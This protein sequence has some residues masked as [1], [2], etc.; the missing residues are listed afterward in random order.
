MT[1][2]RLG[3]WAA[4][5][6]VGL[7]YWLATLGGS[8]DEEAFAVATDSSNNAYV[9]GRTNSTGA[10][11]SDWL[12]VKYN[13]D[14]AVQWQRTL[15]DANYSPANAVAVDSS[16]NI[17]V[18]GYKEDAG[19][20][21]DLIL[22]KYNSSG[23]I[24]WQRVLDNSTSERA[25]AVAVDSSDNVYLF[26][27]SVSVGAG[28]TD[29]F[30]AKYNSSGTIQWQRALGSASGNAQGR[31]VKLDSSDNIYVTGY[32]AQT[33]AGA[34]DVLL[35]KYNS[36]GTLQW[37]RTL[38]GSG[39]DR[40]YGIVIDSNG[41]S[42]AVGQT[43]SAGAGADDVLLAKYNSSGS[44]QWQRILGGGSAE[45]GYSIAADSLDNVYVCGDTSS[46]GAGQGDY[47]IA[48]YNSSGTIQWQ[49]T[50]GGNQPDEAEGIAVDSLDNL[51]VVGTT[52]T[53]GAGNKDFLVAKLPNDGSLTGTYVLDGVNIIY[54]ASTLTAATSSLTS[55]T[56]SLTGV[57]PT[58]TSSTSSLT[59]SSASLT[60]HFVEITA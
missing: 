18:A 32:T 57:T 26:G 55:A 4:S 16:D 12:I 43:R 27:Y 20:A 41:N 30:L 38:G 56:S 39:L 60:S 52:R 48:K 13:A 46:A 49:R 7:S 23:T 22:A 17:Y 28:G 42:Y 59:D 47:I 54:Q 9:V 8:S 44:L 11:S 34:D 53:T 25:F 37:Q 51:Y 31:S 3:F 19:G 6:S 45:V 10:G 50:L 29:F 14:G 33:G 35:A 58:G 21:E 15:G 40:S 1:L 2:I 36:S 5:G 24:Q